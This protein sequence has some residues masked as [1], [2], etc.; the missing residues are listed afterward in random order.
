MTSNLQA[1]ILEDSQY[2]Y[3]EGDVISNIYFLTKGLLGFVLPRKGCC[4]IVIEP[5]DT[6]AVIDITQGIIDRTNYRD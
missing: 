4:Y 3:Q 5:G 6:F 1:K 2:L